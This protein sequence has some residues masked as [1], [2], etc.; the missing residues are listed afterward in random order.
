[1]EVL[2]ST[3]GLWKGTSEVSGPLSGVRVL[4]LVG[5]GPGPFCGMMLADMGADV[6][7][8]DRPGPTRS[9]GPTN[10]LARGQRSIVLN[11]SSP[12]DRD[13]LLELVAASDGFIDP[14]RPGVVER[15]GV[16]PADCLAV[17]PRLVYCRMTGWGQAGP[18]AERAGHD[19]NYIALSGA[20]STCG[21]SGGPPVPPVNMLGDLGGGAMFLAV[22]FLAGLLHARETGQGQVVDA[23]M[24][25][26]SAYLTAMTHMFKAAGKWGPR[27]TNTLDT[28]AP[29]YN[30]YRT[31]DDAFVSVGAIEPEF[32]AEMLD[33]LG[34]SATEPFPTCQNDRALWP[35]MRQRFTEIFA[36]R[37][38]DEWITA[39]HGRDACFA[40]VWDLDEASEEAHLRERGTYVTEFGVRQPAP[41]PRFSVTAGR[42]S[43]PPPGTGAHTAE[44]LRDWGVRRTD[45]VSASSGTL[46]RRREA[47]GGT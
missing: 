20:L 13:T 42:I 30:V 2:K 25:D 46:S 3:I 7:R 28:G 1:V 19:I 11:L 38:R 41:A 8:V 6:V 9:S 14:Y 16:G 5:L 22:G 40:P 43:G 34:L 31:A 37:T 32:Y 44:V 21:A 36:T 15:L 23:A 39:F 10:I 4:Q 35:A 18:Y 29:Y 12:T 26:G 27:G 24:V 47:E 45:D 17:N 33:V